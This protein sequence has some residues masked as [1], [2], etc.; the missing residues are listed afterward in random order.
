ML[1]ICVRRGMQEGNPDT[2]GLISTLRR[3]LGISIQKEKTKDG[4]AQSSRYAEIKR[5]LPGVKL[6]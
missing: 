5:E 3:L 6:S 2:T 1:A 4:S